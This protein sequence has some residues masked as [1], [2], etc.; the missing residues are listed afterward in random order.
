MYFTGNPSIDYLLN[1]DELHWNGSGRFND[2]ASISFSF[3][4]FGVPEVEPGEVQTQFNQAQKVAARLA[5][6]QWATVANVTF[7]EVTD[8]G[9]FTGNSISRGDINFTN[10]A[11]Q[12]NQVLARTFFPAS[13]STIGTPID[14]RLTEESG[15][16]HFNANIADNLNSASL[17]PHG[18]AFSVMMHELGHSLGL[19]HPEDL[20]VTESCRVRCPFRRDGTLGD[21]TP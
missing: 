16:V 2:S 12:S 13:I 10:G 20:P 21:G 3:A 19:G 6:D 14:A 1:A 7:N 9:L 4:R 17:Q 15:D 11:F 5:L 8:T 18:R